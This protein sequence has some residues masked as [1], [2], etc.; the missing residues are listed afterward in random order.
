[1]TPYN[2]KFSQTKRL[3]LKVTSENHVGTMKIV[4]STVIGT[5]LSMSSIFFRELKQSFDFEIKKY[6]FQSEVR[7]K[8]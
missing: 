6:I 1:M 5:P 8:E 7:A 3:L 2:N 4:A